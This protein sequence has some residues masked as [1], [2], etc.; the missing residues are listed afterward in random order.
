MYKLGQYST[1][2]VHSYYRSSL[3]GS[4]EVAKAVG[5]WSIEAGAEKETQRPNW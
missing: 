5:V 2:E 4:I 1:G 3:L